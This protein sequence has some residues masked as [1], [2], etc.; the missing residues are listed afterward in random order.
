MAR[1]FGGL[2]LAAR[3]TGETCA[4]IVIRINSD[5]LFACIFVIR[6]AR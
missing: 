2:Y 5:K 4:R 3:C 1:D 6:L